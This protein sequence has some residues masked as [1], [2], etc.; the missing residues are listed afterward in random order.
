MTLRP[1]SKTSIFGE[2]SVNFGGSRWIDQRSVSA[3]G[4]GFSSTG[5]PMTFQMRPSVTSPT[6]TEIGCPVSMDVEP[7]CEAV[8]GVHRHRAH[9]VVAEMLLHLGDQR[10]SPPVAAPESRARV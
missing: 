6:G 3:G 5:S 7:A 1:V 2:S 8:R 4:A 9:A 10:R